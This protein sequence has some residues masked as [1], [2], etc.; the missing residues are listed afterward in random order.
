MAGQ[1]IALRPPFGGV[2]A[3]IAGLPGRNIRLTVLLCVIAIGGSFAAAGVL[4]FRFET[5]NANRQAAFFQAKRAADI[6]AI[7]AETLARQARTGRAFAAGELY[8]LPPDID[9]I[10]VAD[11]LGKVTAASGVK[12]FMITFPISE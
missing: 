11:V 2:L 3:K 7:A 8:S 5:V 1:D 9:G 12:S 4:Q 10:V 6:A